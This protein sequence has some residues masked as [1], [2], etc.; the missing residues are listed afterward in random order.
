MEKLNLKRL[1]LNLKIE[2]VLYIA[3]FTPYHEFFKWG[4]FKKAPKRQ[5]SIE[6]IEN[7]KDLR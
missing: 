5:N 1:K 3:N 6:I 2:K 4:P 7:F